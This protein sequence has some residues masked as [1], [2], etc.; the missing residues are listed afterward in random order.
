MASP[1]NPLLQLSRHRL[2]VVAMAPLD[3]GVF[4]VDLVLL[5]AIVYTLPGWLMALLTRG[6]RKRLAKS[7]GKEDNSA[8]QVVRLTNRTIAST[9][10]YVVPF[11]LTLRNL[12]TWSPW[13]GGVW[14]SPLD[15]TQNA[16]LH[17]QL[18][19][20]VCDMPYTLLK[21]DTE[22]VIHHV[23]GFGLAVPTVF[24]GK[25]G[26][27]M[28]AILFTEQARTHAQASATAA[29][30]AA[31]SGCL[32]SS[33]L[34]LHAL[35]LTRFPAA[36]PALTAAA[37]QLHLGAL[38]QDASLLPAQVHL[39]GAAAGGRQLCPEHALLLHCQHA[40]AAARGARDPVRHRHPHQGVGQAGAGLRGA[41]AARLRRLLDNAPLELLLQARPAC[42]CERGAA[43]T[44]ACSYQAK[45]KA[46]NK[47]GKA[48]KAK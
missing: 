47:A 18:M 32:A 34:L 16:L 31:A 21:G 37:G 33:P 15:A 48:A 26:L 13:R 9:A 8:T 42:R 38:H 40:A 12:D 2:R 4:S 39:A 11:L 44:P 3:L 35:R 1:R 27:V 22:Q 7:D 24:L 10:M 28:C 14:D 29:A 20:Y 6:A 25:C 17:M 19:Y 46:V 45:I 36:P 41:A 5:F 43:L 30:G 23:I